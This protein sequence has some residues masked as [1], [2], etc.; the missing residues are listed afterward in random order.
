MKNIQSYFKKDELAYLA[1]TGKIE[2]PIRDRLAFRLHKRLK[3]LKIVREWKRTDLAILDSNNIPTR[4]LEL[5]AMYTFD[6]T[7]N[8]KGY[9]NSLIQDFQKNKGLFQKGTECYSIL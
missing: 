4:I 2:H 6:G 8:R 5:K 9:L 7:D 1:L 3:N